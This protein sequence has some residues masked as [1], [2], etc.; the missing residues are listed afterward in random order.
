[1]RRE[2][3]ESLDV[4]ADEPADDAPS[5]EQLA[6]DEQRRRLLAEVLS[7]LPPADVDVLVPFHFAGMTTEEIATEAG[8]NPNTVRGRLMRARGRFP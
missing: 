3:G 5:S 6:A 2:I 4:V 8:L 1:M 7:T